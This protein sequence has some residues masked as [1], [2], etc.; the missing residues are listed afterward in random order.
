MLSSLQSHRAA[1]G[2]MGNKMTVAENALKIVYQLDIFLYTGLS[3][4]KIHA[5][6]LIYY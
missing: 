1:F 5:I 6:A 2:S 3:S 4:V